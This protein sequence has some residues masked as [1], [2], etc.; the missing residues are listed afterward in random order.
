MS[1]AEK[2]REHYDSLAFVYRAFWGDHIH[3]GLFF[4][5][6]PPEQAQLQLLDYSV[7]LLQLRGGET[8]L[9]VG[10]GY[11]GTLLYLARRFGCRG[12]GIT[13]SP[14]Q[15]Q[16]AR[17]ST[18][19]ARLDDRLDFIVEDV[20]DFPFHEAGFDIVWAM[21]SSEHFSGKGRFFRQAASSLRAGGQLFL[22]AWTGS[23]KNQRIREVARRFLCPQLWTAEEYRLSIEAAGLHLL[24]CRDLTARVMPTWA[25]CQER[26]R[27]AQPALKLLPRPVREFVT[28]IEVI[29]DAYRSGDLSYTVMTA[30]NPLPACSTAC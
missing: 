13:I 16:I 5:H 26:V 7:E 29:L 22:A 19:Q 27:L 4:D 15:A 18:R 30:R 14:K 9:D 20:G 28:G 24:R 1:G 23:M 8:V 2:I 12:V 6:E 11:G 10:C 25:I 21:E 3:H 17:A